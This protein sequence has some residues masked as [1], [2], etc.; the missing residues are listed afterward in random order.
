[1]ALIDRSGSLTTP[2][3]Q[4]TPVSESRNL[5]P[6]NQH[7]ATDSDI[8]KIVSIKD[9]F[10]TQTA[11]NPVNYPE[12]YRMLL[13]YTRGYPM[14]VTYFHRQNPNVDIRSFIVSVSMDED[15]IHEDLTKINN[16]EMVL[17]SSLQYE[18]Q[19][20]DKTTALTGAANMYPGLEPYEGDMFVLEVG[21][22]NLVLFTVM[23]VTPTTYRQ[24]RGYR[25][26]FSAYGRLT[27]PLYKRLLS[28]VTDTC[29]F[30]KRKYFGES[31]FTF[32]ST[33]S[34]EQLNKLEHL[35]RAIAQDYVNFFFV[36]DELSFFRPDGVYDPYVTE[37]LRKKLTVLENKVRATQLQVPFRD[38]YRSI[39]YKFI[40][41]ENR[42]DLSELYRYVGIHRKV[43]EYFGAGLNG[44]TG[45]QYLEMQAEPALLGSSRFQQDP[46]KLHHAVRDDNS[47]QHVSTLSGD[48]VVD[49]FA[50]N[51][52]VDGGDCYVFSNDFYN[53]TVT[54]GSDQ[55]EILVNNYLT[56][57][58]INIDEVISI[59]ESYRK[60]GR[61][62]N[63]F[64]R[65][66]IYLELID[67]AIIAVK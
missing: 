46:R 54:G 20:E 60:L 24:E 3:S 47:W 23:A 36:H 44:L 7:M 52:S 25:I 41:A 11:L 19:N 12:E 32:L 62:I 14:S 49:Q 61:G 30:E 45:R 37:F 16:L 48:N 1:M 22:N 38:F 50:A 66:P 65:L 2:S 15:T 31:E 6:R 10:T 51:W 29:H 35:R 43:P 27:E 34:Y 18:L 56:K 28:A 63:A 13:A 26:N 67:A 40:D 21:N 57:N 8:D 64:Y 4:G 17:E 39:W 58:L 55:V 42:H 5:E 9:T 53:N 59:V 33:Q